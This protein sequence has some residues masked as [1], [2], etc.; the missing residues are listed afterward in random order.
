MKSMEF[1]TDV[2]VNG[3][4]AIGKR[5]P[6]S[7]AATPPSTPHASRGGSGCEKSRS[8]ID[9]PVP[10]CGLQGRSRCRD[11]GGH[12]NPFLANPIKVHVEQGRIKAVDCIRMKLGDFDSSGRRRPVPME[13]SEFRVEID[14]LI[15]AIGE[16]PDTSYVGANAGIALTDWDSIKVDE[17]TM[18]TSVSGV[19]AGG[20]PVTRTDTVIDAITAGKRA[21]ESIER[22]VDGVPLE[23]TYEVTKPYM[24]VDAVSVPEDEL[25]DSQRVHAEAMAVAGRV[26]SFEEIVPA[27]QRTRR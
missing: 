8:F 19:F 1:L 5:S 15:T 14:T 3:S 13:G 26:G 24:H 2:N 7:V 12:R 9:E 27:L 20:M 22:W 25:M 18:A 16:R 4:K 6:S 21:A 10:R 17:E 23:R 11:R